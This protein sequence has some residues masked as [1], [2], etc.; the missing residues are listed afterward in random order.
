MRLN[1]WPLWALTISLIV[2]ALAFFVYIQHTTPTMLEVTNAISAFA[3]TTIAVVAISAL[4]MTKKQVNE[5]RIKAIHTALND[6]V[7][8][9]ISAT[10]E[11][12]YFEDFCM[13]WDP[14][15]SVSKQLIGFHKDSK[16]S[17]Q[18]NSHAIADALDQLRLSEAHL[19]AINEKALQK[20]V[21]K[22]SE[23]LASLTILKT[24]SITSRRYPREDTQTK[25]FN[26]A[27]ERYLD[28]TKDFPRLYR[29][30][31]NHLAQEISRIKRSVIKDL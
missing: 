13:H 18:K 3:T 8:K 28:S 16:L 14:E 1:R 7:D 5:W 26:T 24:L 22:L 31:T 2:D 29:Q 27:I 9:V 30:T 17:D 23:V 19:E 10:I 20:E 15:E 6:A 21:E 4:L 12:E 11:I 25:F